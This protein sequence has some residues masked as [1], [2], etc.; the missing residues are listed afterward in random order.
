MDLTGTTCLVTG[1]NRGIGAA[2]ARELATRPR[3]RILAGVRD[4]DAYEPFAAPAGG[5]REV[6]AVRVDLSSRESIDSSWADLDDSQ[7]NIDV[8]VNNAGLMTGGLL[9]DQDLGEIYDL[10]Q[11]NLTGLIHFSRA[12]LTG[13]VA[14]GHGTIVNN[15]SIS[16][17]ASFP[18]ASTYAASK[19]GVVAFSDALRRELRGTGVH[20]LHLVTPGVKTEMLSAT[21]EAYGRHIDTSGW[22]SIPAADWARKTVKA[23]ESDAAVLRPGGR[24]EI[25]RL[26]SRG[27]SFLLDSISR[28]MFT[29]EPRK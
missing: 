1:A 2:F 7:R 22:T 12:V 9:E 27:P 18:S 21:E 20:V 6:T 8:L 29:R 16:G 14:R 23:I 28:R 24:L 10:F 13:M 4:P 26:A 5:A 17:Y 25:A 19:A 11:V 3:T 15:A